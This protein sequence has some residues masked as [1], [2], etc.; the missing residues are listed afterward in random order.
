MPVCR[1]NLF[2]MRLLRDLPILVLLLGVPPASAADRIVS[3]APNFTE[4]LYAIGA[5]DKVLAV[6]DYCQY[7]DEARTKPRVGGPFNLNYE[8]LVALGPD[9]VVL[10][11]SLAGASEK[12]SSLGLPVLALA[13]EKVGEVIASI[14]RLGEV[15]GETGR[16]HRLADGIRPDFYLRRIQVS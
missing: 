7:P 11:L 16:A 3:L 8:R 6:S 15:T 4:I 5:G 2:S 9:L 1:Y 12:V 13:N 14:E 10:P